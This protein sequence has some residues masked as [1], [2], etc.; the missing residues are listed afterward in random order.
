M[1][2][3]TGLKDLFFGTKG[4]RRPRNIS[5]AQS[6]GR[7]IPGME[8]RVAKNTINGPGNGPGQIHVDS[9]SSI[10]LPAWNLDKKPETKLEPVMMSEM[11]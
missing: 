6:E 10:H 9:R 1:Q 8:D 11:Q 5:D 7:K 2:V 3:C 4:P